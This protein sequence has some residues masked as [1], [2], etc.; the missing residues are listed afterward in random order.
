MLLR[1]K[2]KNFLLF[3]DAEFTL[4]KLNTFTGVNLDNLK[5]ASNGSGKSTLAKHIIT[6]A[7]YGEVA[8][9]SLIDLLHD[10]TKEA[11]V[12]IEEQIGNETIRIVRKIP[13][14]LQI[15]VNN[16]ELQMNTTT[17]KQKFIDEKFGNY[18]FFK[19]YRM[20]D[21]KGINLLDSLND[22]RGIITLKKE[23]MSFI[24]D[25]F[26]DI[27]KRLL[28]QKLEKE[29]YNIDKRLYKF[30]L[31]SK[32]EKILNAGLDEIRDDYMAF[33]KDTGIQNE[34]VGT[35][36]SEI[37]SREKIIYY[38][39]QELKKAEEGVCPILKQ[40]CTRI[41]KQM[42][43]S[44]KTASLVEINKLKEEIEQYKK[45]LE[46]EADALNYYDMMLRKM[47]DKEHKTRTRLMQLKEAFK[48]AEYK[49]TA[50]DVMLYTE[51]IKTLDNFAGYYINNWL[52]QL[53][54]IINDLL[55]NVN[56]KVEFNAE[57]EFMRV[58]DTNKG[59]KYAQLSSGQKTFLSAIFKLAILMHKGENTGIIIADEGL[60]D[61]DEVNLKNFIEIC[62]G[63]NF[64]VN[65][66]YQDLPEIEGIKKIEVIRQNNE[67]KIK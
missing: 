4:D 2:V 51:A 66:V 20:V 27:R 28:E 56:L 52:G 11:R 67:S 12:E 14:D 23:L 7:R 25:M 16:K 45:D 48:F 37:L 61:L 32:R 30:Y 57:K 15:F 40:S 10:G 22:S 42:K 18:D 33:E 38:K 47:Q 53:A 24:D 65:L 9:L 17:L 63:L 46:V 26:S 5:E 35:I 49:Y 50:K 3:K 1:L 8:G 58:Y 54:L 44:D 64:Q 36:K 41:G 62:K 59:K 13:T 60:S 39:E 29:T 31:S 21:L 55:K 19:K 34:I 6:F 43:D